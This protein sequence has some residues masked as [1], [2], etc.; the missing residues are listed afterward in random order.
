MKWVYGLV[1]AMAASGQEL[2]LSSLEKLAARAKAAVNVTLDRDKLGIA[3]PF[4]SASDPDQAAVRDLVSSL[5]SINVRTFEFE[6]PG[7]FSKQNDLEPVRRQLRNPGWTKIVDAKDR[8][9][10]V[11]IYMFGKGKDI[12]G[13]T[14][15]SAERR[16]LT[17]VNIVGPIDLKKLGGLAGKFGIPK[18]LPGMTPPKP[19]PPAKK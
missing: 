19:A 13:I 2:D 3:L 17:V 8:D 5:M 15:L 12:G 11:E 16:E 14:I 9:E 4:L 7:S 10:L 1:L 6:G 18:D